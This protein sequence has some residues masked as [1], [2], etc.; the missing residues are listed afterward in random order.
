M[1][2]IIMKSMKKMM[3]MKKI[4]IRILK[5]TNENKAVNEEN[6]VENQEENN[7]KSKE[8]ELKEKEIEETYA[9]TNKLID[10]VYSKSRDFK[11]IYKL[12]KFCKTI[13]IFIIYFK[14]KENV[15]QNSIVDFCY[16]FFQKILKKVN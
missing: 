1:N 7:K 9:P 6:R 13:R 11:I 5:I 2:I 8:K 4:R 10:L 14:N 12:N 16:I 15:T 3:I